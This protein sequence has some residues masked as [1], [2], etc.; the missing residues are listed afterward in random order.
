MTLTASLVLA[1]AHSNAQAIQGVAWTSVLCRARTSAQILACPGQFITVQCVGC[2]RK[3]RTSLHRVQIDFSGQESR[4]LITSLEQ[5][6]LGTRVS[7]WRSSGCTSNAVRPQKAK[8]GLVGDI[9]FEYLM[10][11]MLAQT[12]QGTAPSSTRCFF[13]YDVRRH[14]HF[15]PC[16]ATGRLLFNVFMVE[17]AVDQDMK[18]WPSP[19]R[20]TSGS[21]SQSGNAG[22]S[23][24]ASVSA[25]LLDMYPM[26]ECPNSE[27]FPPTRICN[28]HDLSRLDVSIFW[29]RWWPPCGKRSPRKSFLSHGLN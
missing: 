5:R 11:H 17:A 22:H 20:K 24:N 14:H 27:D 21:G 6:R 29:W 13:H 3:S 19:K 23:K 28:S 15:Q 25:R 8:K 1:L 4:G 26:P 9:I 16:S 18:P 2:E 10:Q 7:T 12:A